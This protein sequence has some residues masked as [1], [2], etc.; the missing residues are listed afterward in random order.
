[1]SPS[2]MVERGGLEALGML[3]PVCVT[4]CPFARAVDALPPPRG[5]REVAVGIA[6]PPSDL[7]TLEVNVASRADVVVSGALL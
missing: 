5:P 2:V 7:F 6:L 1:M 3:H 4:T